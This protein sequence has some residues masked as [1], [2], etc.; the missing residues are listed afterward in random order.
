VVA[1]HLK[2]IQHVPKMALNTPHI[3][4]IE[5]NPGIAPA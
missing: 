4:G 3:K 1:R 5:H 2:E